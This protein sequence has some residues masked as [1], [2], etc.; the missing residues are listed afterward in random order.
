MSLKS[1]RGRADPQCGFGDAPRRSNEGRAKPQGRG[2]HR[3]GLRPGKRG[4]DTRTRLGLHGGHSEKAATCGPGRVRRE[5]APA[6][7]LT[8]EGRPPARGGRRFWRV[9]PSARSPLL[10][11]TVRAH[12]RW[13]TYSP[14]AT[15]P[16][17]TE[18]S[19]S[20]TDTT[21]PTASR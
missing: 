7:A 6:G 1:P 10:Q 9:R 16:L 15:S 3:I 8:A 12:T 20:S 13:A 4:A 2:L 11:Q 14:T 19:P 18:S 5:P 21:V 17:L